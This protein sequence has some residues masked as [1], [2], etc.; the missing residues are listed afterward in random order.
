M[1]NP[2]QVSPSRVQLV[3]TLFCDIPSQGP[4]INLYLFTHL[5]SNISHSSEMSHLSLS[6]SFL[7]FSF[8][9]FIINFSKKLFTASSRFSM[10]FYEKQLSPHLP[11]ANSSKEF[12]NI[13][14]FLQNSC[15]ILLQMRYVFSTVAFFSRQEGFSPLFIFSLWSSG[16]F[17]IILGFS[18]LSSGLFSVVLI[19]PHCVLISS[20]SSGKCSHSLLPFSPLPISPETN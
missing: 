9:H 8:F 1:P 11:L 6:V 4:W 3:G 12:H 13:T 10:D 18:F 5:P 17:S 14:N 20:L 19:F 16:I 15:S 2:V 7:L